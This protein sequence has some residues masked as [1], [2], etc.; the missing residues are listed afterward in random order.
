MLI[1]LCRLAFAFS[2]VPSIATCPSRIQPTRDGFIAGYKAQIAVDH[3]HRIIL[4]QRL[5]GN[6]ADYGALIPLVDQATANLGCA[7][8]EVS[9]DSSFA[10]E[11]NLHA[12]AERKVKAYLAPGRAKHGQPYA[13]GHRRLTGKPLMAAM[14]KKIRK[15]SQNR[16]EADKRGVAGGLAEVNPAMSS[17]VREFG[18]I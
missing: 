3:A 11:A 9:G 1:A 4:A 16:P 18:K 5:T 12:L 15:V 2:F 14:A 10:T 17:L 8:S 13:T 7:L 6:P